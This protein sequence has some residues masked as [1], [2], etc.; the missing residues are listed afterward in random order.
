SNCPFDN[1]FRGL[2]LEKY[3]LEVQILAEI[4][5]K[6]IFRS[7]KCEA[8][9]TKPNAKWRTTRASC[10]FVLSNNWLS[11]C[12]RR[13]LYFD[14][15]PRTCQAAK[16]VDIVKQ[17]NITD[18]IWASSFQ[19]NGLIGPI[20]AVPFHNMKRTFSTIIMRENNFARMK[21]QMNENL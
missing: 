3:M 11:K 15:K 8:Y 21:H 12:Y 5:W 20:G 16:T 10:C 18:N 1:I 6:M 2:S 17:K 13:I 9:C 14:N 4:R 19:T 7:S